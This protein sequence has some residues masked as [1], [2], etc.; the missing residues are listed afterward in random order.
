MTW[1]HCDHLRIACKIPSCCDTLHARKG[2][3]IDTMTGKIARKCSERSCMPYQHSHSVSLHLARQ[4][5]WRCGYTNMAQP[6][7]Q[8]LQQP[9]IAAPLDL[10]VWDLS[11]T[12]HL[13][14]CCCRCTTSRTRRWCCVTPARAPSMSRAWSWSLPSCPRRASG[15]A[16]SA[17]RRRPSRPGARGAQLGEHATIHVFCSALLPSVHQ[18]S[19]ARTALRMAIERKSRLLTGKSA[20]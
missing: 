15:P 17:P 5:C 4:Y 19:T 8:L 10:S 2:S 13:A 20:V 6:C 14:S 9:R 11:Q 1:M 3:C 18:S 7:A 16:P 12:Q